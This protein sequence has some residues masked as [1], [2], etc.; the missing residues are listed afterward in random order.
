[1]FTW[2]KSRA[3]TKSKAPE[4]Y[5]AVVAQARNPA[6]Y[7]TLGVADTLEGRYELIALHLVLVLDRLGAAD[8]ADEAFQRETMEA[9]VAD[10]DGAMRQMG[11]GDAGMARNVKK[12]AGGV[13]ARSFAYRAALARAGNAALETALADHVYYGRSRPNAGP[14]A[15]YVRAA[16]DHLA[17]LQARDLSAGKIGFPQVPGE[18][19]G[20]S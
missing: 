20:Q 17:A 9:F 7:R 18:P 16:V 3:P 12:A 15:W 1:M 8:I 6:F 19:G 2:L 4:L 13:H 11:I 10:M 14:L 5:G